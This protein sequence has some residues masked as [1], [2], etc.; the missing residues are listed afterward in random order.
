MGDY[1]FGGDSLAAL[2]RSRL[3]CSAK[4]SLEGGSHKLER[5]ERVLVKRG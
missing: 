2:S 4:R 5:Q 3:K 1:A